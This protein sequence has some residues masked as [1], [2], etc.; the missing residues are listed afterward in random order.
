MGAAVAAADPIAAA[1]PIVVAERPVGTVAAGIAVGG[2][3][4]RAV[5][6]PAAAGADSPGSGSPG[7][8]PGPAADAAVASL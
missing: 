2:I 3:A 4:G 7:P 5:G 6:S 1:G 8:G